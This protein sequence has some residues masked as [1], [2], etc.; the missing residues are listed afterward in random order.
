VDG[1][2]GVPAGAGTLPQCRRAPADHPNCTAG[3]FRG[4]AVVAEGRLTVNDRLTV[5]ELQAG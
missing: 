3:A 2:G 5:N 4:S 1:A